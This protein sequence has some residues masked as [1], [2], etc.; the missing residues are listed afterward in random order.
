[1]NNISNSRFV[2]VYHHEAVEETD[3]TPVVVTE[4]VDDVM[5]TL[6]VGDPDSGHVLMEQD[7]QVYLQMQADGKRKLQAW[8][9]IM[10]KSTES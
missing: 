2:P 7:P 4:E 1:M 6:E 8:P 10:Y 9:G 5:K 3:N